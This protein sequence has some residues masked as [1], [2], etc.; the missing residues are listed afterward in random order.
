L[1]VGSR[2]GA[3]ARVVASGAPAASLA[4]ATREEP[5]PA[6]LTATHAEARASSE[7]ERG[8]SALSTCPSVVAE[9]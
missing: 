1:L 5:H 7:E 9:V 3:L 6:R 8:S 2:A 4:A